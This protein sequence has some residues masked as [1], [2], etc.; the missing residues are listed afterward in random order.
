MKDANLVYHLGWATNGEYGETI[1]KDFE[2]REETDAPILLDQW[3]V[4]QRLSH[5]EGE[6]LTLIE[7]TI[8]KDR[9]K[10]TKDIV[11]NIVGKFYAEI[12]NTTHTEDYTQHMCDISNPKKK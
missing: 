3:W 7:A 10:A 6:I 4:T 9:Q 5:L 11:R 8:E 2:E 12:V 1:I